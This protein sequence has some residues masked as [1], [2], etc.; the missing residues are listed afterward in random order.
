MIKNRFNAQEGAT[1]PLGYDYYTQ[2]MYANKEFILNAINY[3]AGDEEMLAT[4]S[5]NIELRK[6]DVMKVKELRT[7]YQL[8]N[9]LIPVLAVAL[10]GVI[11]LVVRKRKYTK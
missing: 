7:R 6:L 11:I 8:I 5:R 1:Y 2:T 4:R 10:A 3:L 9:I